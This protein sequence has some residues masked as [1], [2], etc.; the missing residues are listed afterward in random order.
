MHCDKAAKVYRRKRDAFAAAAERHLEG[1]A[2]WEV[3]T[4]GMFFWLTL[5]LPPGKDSFDVLSK[6]GLDYGIL[7]IPGMAFLPNVRK[8]SQIRASY[9]LVREEDMDE[10]CQR[11]ARLV[12]DAWRDELG[13]LD[14]PL[15]TAKS[16]V[17]PEEARHVRVAP[18]RQ[19]AA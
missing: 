17:Y 9:S 18:T 12:D 8:A 11:I 15:H 19:I 4:A 2:T 6:K 16:D 5:L 7:A 3:P 10:A 1:K 13:Q 14:R